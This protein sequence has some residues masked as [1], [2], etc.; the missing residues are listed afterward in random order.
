VRIYRIERA[1]F[2]PY[3]HPTHRSEV[4]GLDGFSSENRP[5]P[6]SDGL[7]RIIPENHRYG[8]RT[9]SLMK[10]WFKEKDRENLRKNH[11][12]CRVYEVKKKHVRVGRRQVT[13]DITKARRLKEI[14]S[15]A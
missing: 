8:F 11:F 7:G 13:F 5:L 12:R 10:E 6:H 4:I 2:G 1:G 3:R 14:V 9:K 15:L